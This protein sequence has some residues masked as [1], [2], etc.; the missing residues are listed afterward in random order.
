MN[1]ISSTQRQSSVLTHPIAM[2]F[3]GALVLMA[4]TQV[5][6]ALPFTP[7]PITGQTFA[8]ILWP[9]LFGR[10]IGLGSIGIYLTAGALG[11]PVFAGFTA[12]VA[13]W[14]PT[15]GYLIGFVA[16]TAIV[17]TMRDRGVTTKPLGTVF[18]II[19][20]TSVILSCG[21]LVLGQ[22]VGYSNVWMM[23]I[24]PFLLGDVVK[25]VLLMISARIGTWTTQN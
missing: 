8:V 17:G 13:L 2:S 4:L 19:L 14:G 6:I 25:T 10:S 1:S 5:R 16:A 21:A 9:L 18:A 12:L 24:A 15:S 3:Y 11:L 20:A 7:V 23:G 22:F